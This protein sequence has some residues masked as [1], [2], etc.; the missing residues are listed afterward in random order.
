M[1]NLKTFEELNEGKNHLGAMSKSQSKELADAAREHPTLDVLAH[2]FSI[3]GNEIRVTVT[4]ASYSQVKDTKEF[5]KE[6]GFETIGSGEISA[7]AGPDYQVLIFK[8]K[9]G[10]QESLY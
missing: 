7:E 5:L 6:N 1:K 4:K 10:W 2:E 8:L 3:E 9:P